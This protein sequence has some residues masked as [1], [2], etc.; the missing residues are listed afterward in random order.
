MIFFLLIMSVFVRYITT[1]NSCT[2]GDDVAF[3]VVFGL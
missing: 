3:E 2:L 1:Y